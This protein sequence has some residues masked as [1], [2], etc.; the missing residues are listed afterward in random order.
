[1][2]LTHQ[3]T[4]PYPAADLRVTLSLKLVMN[5]ICILIPALILSLRLQQSPSGIPAWKEI[6][7]LTCPLSFQT[8]QGLPCSPK[9]PLNCTSVLS[10]ALIL[11]L[12]VEEDLRGTLSPTLHSHKAQPFSFLLKKTWHLTF[13]HPNTQFRLHFRLCSRA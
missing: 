4:Y 12:R 3:F 8:N 6:I 13:S 7:S 9:C 11:A 2:Q 5:F 10:T 1:M